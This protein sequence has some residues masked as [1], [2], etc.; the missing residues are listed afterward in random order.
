MFGLETITVGIDIG[1]ANIKAVEVL[2]KKSEVIILNNVLSPLPPGLIENGLILD[3]VKVGAV[4]YTVLQQLSGKARY[5]YT[6]LSSKAVFTRRFS[7]PKISE[8][9]LE[10]SIK[11]EAEN[12]LPIS[13]ENAVYDFQYWEEP[14]QEK[15]TVMLVAT[16]HEIINSYL[17]TFQSVELVPK[18]FDI[19]PLSLSRALKYLRQSS[20]AAILDLGASNAK[21]SIF[22]EGKLY[23]TR[24]INIGG[25]HFT[26][27]MANEKGLDFDKAEELKKNLC[28][29]FE[30]HIPQKVLQELILELE[31]SFDYFRTQNPEK[32]ITCVY[33]TGGGSKMA[34]VQETLQEHLGINVFK[35]PA[36]TLNESGKLPKG[37]ELAGDSEGLFDLALG[38]ALR[39][40]NA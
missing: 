40:E 19:E 2:Q 14:G 1:S 9:E 31:R 5:F 11:W 36:L 3:P 23:F 32:Q 7:M 17:Q 20:S 29:D 15:W 39:R 13:L 8:K 18:A 30:H 4:L 27:W 34:G 28:C 38:L 21:L 22:W 37:E 6:A 33:L 25:K 16:T 26:Q 10:D 35:F 12:Q 24:A